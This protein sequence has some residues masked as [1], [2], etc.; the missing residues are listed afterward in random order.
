MNSIKNINST[1]SIRNLS[2]SVEWREFTD[3]D[4]DGLGGATPFPGDGDVSEPMIAE[5]TVDG[6][7]AIAVLDMMGLTIEVDRVLG[8]DISPDEE[9][10]EDEMP[11]YG[12]TFSHIG[13]YAARAVAKLKERML[14]ADIDNLPGCKEVS[15]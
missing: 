14:A 2:K 8:S 11:M 9:D 15:Y 1:S 7:P 12:Y 5:L 10:I 6:V 3:S 13:G 4:W